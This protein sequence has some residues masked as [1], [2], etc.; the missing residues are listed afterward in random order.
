MGFSTETTMGS[1]FCA[2]S[3]TEKT[4]STIRIR[5]KPIFLA[6]L[7]K[8]MLKWAG[9]ILQTVYYFGSKAALQ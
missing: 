6:I 8:L 7:L 5:S 1:T 4:N 3:C 2:D 9:K